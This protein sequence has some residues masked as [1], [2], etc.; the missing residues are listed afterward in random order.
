[1]GLLS[2]YPICTRPNRENFP[3]RNR[4]VAGMCDATILI[5]SPVKGGAMITARLAESY[6]RDV[7]AVPGLPG[8][9]KKA[10]NHWL[11]KNNKAALLENANDLLQYMNWDKNAL[12][13]QTHLHF[14]LSQAEKKLMELF[15]EQE[16]WH[17]DAIRGDARIS[18]SDVALNLLELEL[19]GLIRT[20]AG[21]RFKK[22]K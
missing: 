1:G 10:G 2:E 17:I 19:K 13:R 15:Q 4:I 8:D 5:E 16:T 20:L 12:G 21:N 9:P 7:F 6:N 18:S 22:R 11:I 14:E 3:T